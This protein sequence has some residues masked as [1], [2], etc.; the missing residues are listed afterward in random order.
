VRF[1]GYNLTVQAVVDREQ[2]YYYDFISS[3]IQHTWLDPGDGYWLQL[4]RGDVFYTDGICRGSSESVPYFR[5]QDPLTGRHAVR[6]YN[7]ES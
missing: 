5:A 3:L 4:R 6:I 7:R 2:Y 1:K